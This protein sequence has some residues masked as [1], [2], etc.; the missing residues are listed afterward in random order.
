MSAASDYLRKVEAGLASGITTEHSYRGALETYLDSFFPGQVKATNEPTRAECGAPDFVVSRM[1]PAGPQTVGYLECK[2][3]GA[4]LDLAERTEQL[5]RY[6][7]QLSNLVLTNYLEFRW[8]IDGELRETK[9]L[10]AMT[11]GGGL[12]SSSSQKEAVELLV[13]AFESRVPPSVATAQELAVRLARLTHMIRDIVV[14][15][16]EKKKASPTLLGIRTA[17]TEVLL[18]H[19]AEDRAN[20]EFADM[21]AQTIA[22]G[23]FAAR[24]NH[25]GPKPFQRI[26]AAEEIPRINPLLRQLFDTVTGAAF[27]DEPYIG[28]I[29]D[30]ARLLG[31]ADMEAILADFGSVSGREDPVVHFYETYLQEYDPKLREARGVYFTP[32]PVVSYIVRS[33]DSL[34]K[35]RFDCREGLS[36]TTEV[37]V[38]T[39]DDS[40]QSPNPTPPRQE[41]TIHRVLVLD[42]ACGTGT[43][44]YACI[45]AI[46]SKMIRQGQTG[47]WSGYVSRH[48][49]PRFFGFELLIAPYAI[50]H[51]KLSLE[52]QGHDLTPT[53]R[54]A[55]AYTPQKPDR[56]GVFLTNTLEPGEKSYKGYF[57]PL[58]QTITREAASAAGIKGRLP[59]LVV[60]GN[61]PYS[62]HSFNRNP[63]IESLVEDYKRGHPELYKP[64]QAKWLQND[65]VKFI[66]FGQWRIDKTGSGILAFITDRGYLDNTTFKGMRQQLLSAFSDIY[67]L[68]LHGGSKRKEMT[69]SGSPDANVFDIQQ[70]VCIGI[71]LRASDAS[72]P[73]RVRY[74][75]IRGTREEKYESLTKHD[76]AD[77]S[78]IELT[79]TEP[80]YLFIPV[81]ATLQTEYDQ[82]WPLSTIFVEAGA[83]APG[84]VTTQDEF[85]ISFSPEDA[86][87]K[88]VKFLATESEAEARQS[89]RLCTQF[90]WNYS[91]AKS[92]L[93]QGGWEKLITPVVYRPF[94]LRW[95]V[96]DSNVAVHRRDRVMRHLRSAGNLA[97]V[98]PRRVETSDPWTHALAVRNIV[99]HVAVSSKSID[100]VFPL[101]LYPESAGPITTD[102]SQ[103]GY[104]L[105]SAGATLRK[106]SLNAAFVD[107]LAKA[108]KLKYL[109]DGAGDLISS[110][111]PEDVFAFVYGVLNLPIYRERF[112]ALLRVGFARIPIPSGVQTFRSVTILGHKLIA[113]HTGEHHRTPSSKIS[114]PR[115]GS[116]EI[117]RGCPRFFGV[118]ST[119]PGEASA[120]KAGR[121]YLSLDRAGNGRAAQFFDQVPVETWEWRVGGYLPAQHWL[122]ARRLRALTFDD[123]DGYIGLLDSID[124]TIEAIARVE[125]DLG[126]WP[127]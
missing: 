69:P 98:S 120:I 56:L 23:F 52:L 122:K 47:L 106:P 94:D 21:L 101:Y 93:S 112:D 84:L 90:Q 85:A 75:E 79:P 99:D 127:I 78:W 26:G 119:P 121:I 31:S 57:D 102:S 8:Y 43:F 89:W 2:D 16:F 63:W 97:L 117:E 87:D 15:A 42:P 74:A 82:G 62:G 125:R 38:Q 71:F 54:A 86:A 123:L 92:G 124:A 12:K 46:R 32:E 34:L 51:F 116:N 45:R 59:I 113:L 49:L 88:V 4:S 13:G 68:D 126:K 64:G 50:A 19:L 96:Y 37:K 91:R 28:F 24:V 100:Y 3:V 53:E 40:P 70:G 115:A 111:G 5:R 6:R 41:Q 14:E 17:F 72:R 55:I 83:P 33:V 107:E 48:I 65:Y 118:G 80:H 39:I 73:A 27:A 7:T 18:P 61:P 81:D 77:T 114:F 110:F 9:S 58:M 60:M 105:G 20:P 67:I 29:D 104:V 25:V 76:V 66:R 11:A 108:T 44:L 30:L 36:D 95:T 1:D 22:Y 109:E 10:A 103:T 35:S